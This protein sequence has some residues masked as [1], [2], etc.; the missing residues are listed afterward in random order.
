L[1]ETSPIRVVGGG[2]TGL[3]LGL[4]LAQKGYRVVVHE[5]D[6]YLGGLTGESTL[7][8]IPVER[9]YHCVL[10]GDT[11]LLGLLEESG[12]ENAVQWRKT[13][14]GFLHGGQLFEMT[15]VGDFL[16]FPPLRPVDRLRLGWTVGYCGML[17]DWRKLD[18]SAISSF[19]RRHSGD[20]VFESIWEPLLIAKLGDTYDRFSASYIWATIVRML[21]ARR[22]GDRS[23]KLGFVSGRYGRVFQTLRKMIE[24]AGGAVET[25]VAVDAVRPSMGESGRR[26]V[27]GSGGRELPASGVVLTVP[28]PVAVSLL[29]DLPY[30][31]KRLL[32]DSDYI[33]VLCE[34]LLLRQSLTPY[35]VINLTDRGLPFTGVIEMSN[36]AGREEYGGQTLVYLPRYCVQSAEQWTRED[37]V[38]HKENIL[39]LGKAIPGFRE[40]DIVAWKVHRARFV[41]PVHPVGGSER[42]IPVA[43]A[44]G[45]AYL[46][47]AHIRP[48]PVFNNEVVRLVDRRL[49][50]VI[51]A[52]GQN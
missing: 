43:L 35:Y 47:T 37:D 52:T 22:S 13:R 15:T 26:W 33:G 44:P 30:E 21:S 8:G 3:T 27:V 14:T 40:R 48:W 9:F 18:R 50:D 24:R 12:L 28:A 39:A 42:D 34:V 17:K 10:P 11:A 41:Q 29:G 25:G 36:L 51:A 6:P 2:M 32:E 16:R 1:A 20:R 38:L 23:E 46:S 45:L 49:A 19:L 4:R 31:G 7:G 5:R